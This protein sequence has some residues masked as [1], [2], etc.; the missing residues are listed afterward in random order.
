[1]GVTLSVILIKMEI[2]TDIWGQIA[3]EAN[4]MYVVD[5]SGKIKSPF[6]DTVLKTVFFSFEI[7]KNNLIFSDNRKTT[8]QSIAEYIFISTTFGNLSY[9]KNLS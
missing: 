7:L 6:A 5:A 4:Q 9:G 8:R 1:M 3:L 2:S